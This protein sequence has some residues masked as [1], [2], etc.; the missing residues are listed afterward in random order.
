MEDKMAAGAFGRARGHNK[1]V[2]LF[3][4]KQIFVINILNM[5]WNKKGYIYNT[6]YKFYRAWNVKNYQKLTRTLSLCVNLL[7]AV[8]LVDNADKSA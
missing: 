2:R 4:K 6:V 1:Q 5:T 7:W 3:D 8:G